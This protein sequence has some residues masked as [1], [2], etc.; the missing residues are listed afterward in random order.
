MNGPYIVGVTGGSASGKTLF[1]KKL[2][3]QFKENELCI[4]SQD[5]YYKP[6]ELQPLDE[7]GIP[8]FDTPFSIDSALFAADLNELKHGRSVTRPRYTFNNPAAPQE[9]LVF[10]PAPVIIVEGIFVFYYP[11]LAGQFDLKIFIDAREHVKLSRRIRRDQEERGYSVEDVLYRYEKHVAPTYEKY[12]APLK[13]EADLVIP[14]NR[15]FDAALGV[16]SAFFRKK[17]EE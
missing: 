2:A 16:L 5:N 17:I 3:K 10:K 11:D 12:I 9:T 1:L 14:N 8:N 6:R 4:V 15:G 13:Y 7:E